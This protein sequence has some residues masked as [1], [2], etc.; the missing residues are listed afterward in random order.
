MADS[1]QAVGWDLDST[2]AS[3]LHRRH[4]VPEIKAGRAT[5]DD[6]SDLSPGDA[7]IAG[8]V[9][10]ARLL[11]FHGHPQYAISGRSG[12]AYARTVSWL[13]EHDVPMNGVILRPEGDCTDNKLF[14]VAKI[15][16]LQAEGIEFCL[17]VEDWMPVAEYI[18]EQTGIPVLGVNPFDEG[19]ALVTRDQL[20]V[21]IDELNDFGFQPGDGPEVADAIFPRLGGAF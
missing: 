16:E 7:P 8:A 18:T 20:A 5:W 11:H 12:S 2:L 19:S 3:T 6:Y 17:F 9:A 15:R 21:V 10:L 14:K 1:K 13:N 4:L